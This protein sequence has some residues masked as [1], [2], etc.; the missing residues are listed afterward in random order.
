V[1]APLAGWLAL[2]PLAE[3]SELATWSWQDPSAKAGALCQPPAG[4]CGRKSAG[5]LRVSWPSLCVC[6]AGWLL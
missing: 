3:W 2:V 4:Q 1:A 6:A 5:W